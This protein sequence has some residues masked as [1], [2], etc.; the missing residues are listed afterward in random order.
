MSIVEYATK[1]KE[2]SRYGYAVIDT[3]IK[4]NEF[5][6]GPRPKLARMTMTHVRDPCNIVVEMAILH[7]ELLADLAKEKIV[8]T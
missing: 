6:R 1:F 5:I 4:R 3:D 2:L 7:E 8:E